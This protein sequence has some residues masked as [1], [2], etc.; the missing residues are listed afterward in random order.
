VAHWPGDPI[1]EDYNRHASTHSVDP[2]QF[3]QFNSLVSLMLLVSVI[4]EVD[5]MRRL[6]ERDRPEQNR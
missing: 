5:T 4:L 2:L 3:T 1:P 6:A